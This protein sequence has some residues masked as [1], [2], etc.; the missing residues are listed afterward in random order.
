[1]RQEERPEAG[2]A[3]PTRGVDV[4]VPE[5]GDHVLPGAIDNGRANGKRGCAGVHGHDPPAAYYHRAVAEQRTT[6]HVD[7][8]DAPDDEGGVPKGWVTARVS[9]R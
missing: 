5:A 6:L 8:R 4:H 7:D 9:R 3:S 1:M 2:R